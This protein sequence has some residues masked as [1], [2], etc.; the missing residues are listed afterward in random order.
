MGVV[1][2][3]MIHLVHWTE[4]NDPLTMRADGIRDNSGRYACPG[5]WPDQAL[6]P[7]QTECPFCGVKVHWSE[8][9]MEI[10]TARCARGV[11]RGSLRAP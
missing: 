7:G 8:K 10:W 9:L 1:E 5:C 6:T 2:P 11:T 4:P 3:K